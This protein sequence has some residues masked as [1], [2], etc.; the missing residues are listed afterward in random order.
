M[1]PLG[2]FGSFVLIQSIGIAAFAAQCAGI[3]CLR[4]AGK[5][6]A[7]WTMCAGL[8]L[9]FAG[10]LASFIRIFAMGRSAHASEVLMIIGLGLPLLSSLTFAIGFAIH[11]S[12]AARAADRLAELESLATEMS[13]EISR[14]RQGGPAK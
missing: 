12:R 2:I 5:D 3:I 11:G 10:I 14:L 6:A 1:H 7:W 8:I 4:R 13:D 9:H